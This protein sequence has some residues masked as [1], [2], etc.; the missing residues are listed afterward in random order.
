[1]QTGQRGPTHSLV[2]RPG[3][4]IHQTPPGRGDSTAFIDMIPQRAGQEVTLHSCPPPPPFICSLLV[5]ADGTHS[6]P[7]SPRGT[8]RMRSSHDWHSWE[9]SSWLRQQPLYAR[10]FTREHGLLS[11]HIVTSHLSVTLLRSPA[12]CSRCLPDERRRWKT[13]SGRSRLPRCSWGGG[14]PCWEK[15]TRNHEA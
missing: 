5:K 8:C 12:F 2:P 13:T 1:M 7:P 15:W 3:S 11:S 10:D 9:F 4:N 6:W 14:S